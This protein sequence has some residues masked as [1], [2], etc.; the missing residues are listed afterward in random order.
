MC[1]LKHALKIVGSK[2]HRNTDRRPVSLCV[3]NVFSTCYFLQFSDY[4]VILDEILNSDLKRPIPLP[5]HSSELHVVALQN[6]WYVLDY[7]MSAS[8]PTCWHAIKPSHRDTIEL[9][10]VTLELYYRPFKSIYAPLFNKQS[11][12]R[13]M[14][15]FRKRFPTQ[16]F[17]FY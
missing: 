11:I 7:R 16:L 13:I 8:T 15:D 5:T 12:D 6:I 2:A 14:A 1:F 3:F 9:L 17:L 10:Y 4:H